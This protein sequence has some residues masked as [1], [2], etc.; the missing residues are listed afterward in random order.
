MSVVE[1]KRTELPLPVDEKTV[2]R[3]DIVQ[4]ASDVPSKGR[5]V[6]GRS[7]KVRPQKRASTL[8]KT[9]TNNQV[10]SF[11]ERLKE[12][13][14]RKES[15]ELQAEL[16]EERRQTKVVKK[17]RRLE[18]EKKRAENEYKQAQKSAK[19]L[20]LGKLSSTLKAMSKKQLRQVK[21]TR[22][23]TKTGVV[24]FVPAYSK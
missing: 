18:N 5:S 21:K 15:L 9:K 12:K 20:N 10:K 8:I 17:E 24:E 2:M 7:W 6:S 23:N 14:E 22:I 3:G 16:R 11:Q 1:A 4:M 19:Q 13:R